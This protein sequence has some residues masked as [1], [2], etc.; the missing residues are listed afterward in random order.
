MAVLIILQ[1]LI[2]TETTRV[3]QVADN[4]DDKWKRTHKEV[5]IAIVLAFSAL[6][7]SN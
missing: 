4:L 1:Q 6:N 3:Q 7:L 2:I 5:V